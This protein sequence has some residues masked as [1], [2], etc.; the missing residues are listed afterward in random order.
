MEE[1]RKHVRVPLV[2][3][4]TNR[5]TKEFHFFYSKDISLGGMF[6][7]TRDPYPMD[8]DVELDFFLQVED[9]KERVIMPG[10]V[11]RVVGYDV[12]EKGQQTPG[13]GIQFE[14]TAAETMA[15]IGNFIRLSLEA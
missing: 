2:V 4:V 5:K 13:M 11:K 3:K 15:M 7:E 10:K 9:H 1:K 6:L 8:S 12:N 14:S